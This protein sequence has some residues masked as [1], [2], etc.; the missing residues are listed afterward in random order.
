MPIETSVFPGVDYT[1]SLQE[2]HSSQVLY[3]FFP[4]VYSVYFMAVWEEGRGTVVPPRTACIGIAHYR[5]VA[6]PR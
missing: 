2:S 5:H 6:W 1:S 4:P 3:C